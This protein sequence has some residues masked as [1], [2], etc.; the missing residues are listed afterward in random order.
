MPQ[1]FTAKFS[2]EGQRPEIRRLVFSGIPQPG[3]NC[4]DARDQWLDY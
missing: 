1:Q 2:I 3:A 4:E